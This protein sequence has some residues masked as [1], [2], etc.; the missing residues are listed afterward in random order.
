MEVDDSANPDVNSGS[1]GDAKNNGKGPES[2]KKGKRK[3]FVGSQALGYRR[4]HM[5]VMN[6]AF[7]SPCHSAVVVWWCQ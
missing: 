7:M 5:E 3:L 2:E 6:C 4:D 1:A